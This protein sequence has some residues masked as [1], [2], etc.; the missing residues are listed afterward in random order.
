MY[1]HTILAYFLTGLRKCRSTL[2]NAFI[3]TLQ[4]C[5]NLLFAAARKNGFG[6]IEQITIWSLLL[7]ID[8]F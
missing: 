5:P 8:F 2:S 7:V 3:V 1:I 4:R 6:V